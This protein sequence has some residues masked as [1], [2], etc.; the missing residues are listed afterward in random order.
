MSKPQINISNK[1]DRVVALIDMD[2]KCS[3][4]FDCTRFSEE[5]FLSG[6]YCQVEERLDPAL[7]G[8]PI[9]VVQYNAWRGGG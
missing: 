4:Q 6:F 7:K 5:D 9:A 1:Y 8:K 3:S 2:C